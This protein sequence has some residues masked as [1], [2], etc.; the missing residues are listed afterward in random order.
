MS[1]GILKQTTVGD[2]GFV[3]LAEGNWDFL[4][5]ASTIKHPD[6]NVGDRV[7][8]PDGRVFR[9]SKA[10]TAGVVPETGAFNS[11]KTIAVAVAPAQG[12]GCG[13]KGNRKVTI[14]VDAAAGV[15]GDGV[16]AADELK[17]G[18]IVIGNGSAQHPQMR[19]IISNPAVDGAATCDL[20]LDAPLTTAV[21]VGTT[22]L[23]AT[24]NPY[25]FLQ[26]GTNEYASF[27]GIPA[28]SATVGQYFWLQ[29]WGPCWITSNS[30][31]CNS[32]NDRTI[33]FVANGSVVSSDDVTLESGFQIAGFAMDASSSGASNAPMVMLQISI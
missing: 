11:I 25:N 15:A 23:E 27:L 19:Q 32:A 31:T 29:T 13:A 5:E 26:C 17:G 14:T 12:T 7:V 9:Y 8:L 16:F 22:T 6:F 30:N 10:G 3:S 4:Y 21:T 18:Y 20:T 28:I 2:I 1:K 24:M 33:V